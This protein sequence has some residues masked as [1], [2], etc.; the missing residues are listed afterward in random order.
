MP[1][2]DSLFGYLRRAAAADPRLPAVI[3]PAGSASFAELFERSEAVAA[4]LCARGLQ[5]GTRVA[6]FVRPSPELIIIVYA[7][8]RIGAV[9]VLIDPGMGRAAL[10]RCLA[11]MQ[12]G[13]LIGIPLAHALR[14]LAPHAF[15]STKLFVCVGSSWFPSWLPGTIT[16][17]A[18]ERAGRGS[19]EGADPAPADEAAILFTSGST[20]PAKGVSYTHSNFL[21]QVEALRA[22]YALG[23]GQRDLACFP[24]FALFNAAFQRTSVFPRLDP[25]RPGSVDPAML[26]ETIMRERI[27]DTFG[28]PAIWKRVVPWARRNGTSF[29]ELERVMIAGASVPPALIEQF[30]AVL[31]AH[32]EVHTPYGATEALPVASICGREILARR[33]RIE[34]GHGVCVGRAAPGLEIALIRIDDEPL[35]AWN[36]SLALPRGSLGE[37]AVRGPVVTQS[38]AGLESATRASKI[39]SSMGPWH[40]MGDVGY[41]DSDGL[42]WFTGRKSQRLETSGGMFP[43]EPLERI[44]DSM[45]AIRRSAVVGAGPRGAEQPLLI[46]EGERMD[47][48][49]IL[50]FARNHARADLPHP[51]PG[52]QRVLFHPRFPV[53]VRHNAKIRREEL[54]LWAEEQLR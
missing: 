48:D 38:Y 53:D 8:F 7:L 14:W 39:A 52:I 5:R 42:L 29:R 20:G 45:P 35:D 6:V 51:L 30:H 33:E 25:S 22:M 49:A 10:I 54:K 13:A 18:L 4:G 47:A 24:L 3:S 1:P 36:D 41:L 23:P 21:A 9:P 44:V 11:S 31:P 32:G 12:I 27:T 46:I 16:L 2:A 17:R 37:I 26:A 40:R 34:G 15:G 28:S 50:E 43:P 19:F